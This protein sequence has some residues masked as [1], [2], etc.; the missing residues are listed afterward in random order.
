MDDLQTY[1]ISNDLNNLCYSVADKVCGNKIKELIIFFVNQYAEH[2]LDNNSH[3]LILIYNRIHKLEYEIKSFFSSKTPVNKHI[4]SVKF[5][6][7]KRIVRITLCELFVILVQTKRFDNTYRNSKIKEYND[8]LSRYTD[9]HVNSKMVLQFRNNY[10]N[11][12]SYLNHISEFVLVV[13]S[14]DV[15]YYIKQ[16]VYQC[17]HEKQSHLICELLNLLH[18]KKELQHL[19]HIRPTLPQQIEFSPILESENTILNSSMKKFPHIWLL[20]Y[21]CLSLC[22]NDKKSIV[23]RKL[24]LY[25]RNITTTSILTKRFN[26]LLSAFTFAFCDIPQYHT[27]QLYTPIVAQC[28]LK[29]DY[30]YQEKMEEYTKLSLEEE[31][32]MKKEKEDKQK[33]NQHMKEY[34]S[35]LFSLPSIQPTT[36]Q[37]TTDQAKKESTTGDKKN[38]NPLTDKNIQFPR[39]YKNIAIEKIIELEETPVK[40]IFQPRLIENPHEN[41]I[42]RSLNSIKYVT[43]NSKYGETIASKEKKYIC[44]KIE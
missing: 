28:A 2:Y 25:T 29:V 6:C 33:E 11:L 18:N 7:N 41:N 9:R 39:G 40:H 36:D 15:I 4:R 26:L 1:L 31:F 37:P 30:I 24:Y 43:I 14:D 17:V 8:T 34:N 38:I 44:K 16:L 12:N 10:I 42:Y 13:L 35:V 23:E 5:L 19:L 3:S 27:N 32:Q 20:I 21:L 22:P